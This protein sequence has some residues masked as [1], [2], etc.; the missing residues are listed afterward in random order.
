MALTLLVP[1]G[2]GDFSAMYQKLCCIP[3]DIVIRPS[4][5]MP[6][7]I[8]PFLDI[9]P[10]VKNGG[11]SGH[12]A[13]VSVFQTLPPGTD[14][15]DL[16]DGVYILAIN[17][18]LENGGK[19]ADWIPG[20]TEYH[21]RT[22]APEAEIRPLGHFL[23][24]LSG[25]PLVGVYCSAYGNS[26]HWGFW[27]TEEWR[28]FLEL[29]RADLPEDTEYIFIGAEYDVQIADYLAKWMGATGY[30][31]YDTLGKFHIAATI[32]LIRKL[33]YFFVFPSGLGFLADVVRTPNLMWFPPH[34][35]PMRG[36]FCDPEQYESRQSLHELFTSPVKAYEVFKK[37]GYRHLE[38]RQ[39]ATNRS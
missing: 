16:P 38:E 32:E 4:A 13:N 27:G 2:I 19:V 23:S 24:G 31:A 8:G 33:D 17:T 15:A 10:N 18:F 35:D 7:R 9:L 37:Y 26:R 12:N 6:E 14:I 34:L 25:A 11:Y 30:N 20:Q 36:T 3:R 5:D 1:P 21:Y 39:N 28:E 22:L 29:V